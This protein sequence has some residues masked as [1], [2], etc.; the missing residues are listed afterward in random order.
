MEDEEFE[1]LF[2]LEPAAGP[3]PGN[4]PGQ[5]SLSFETV[6]AAL[7]D[8]GE[9]L[10]TA[11]GA[12]QETNRRIEIILGELKQEV[13]AYCG[14]EGSLRG[15]GAAE[16]EEVFRAM[17]ELCK[18]L[19]MGKF[20]VEVERGSAEGEPRGRRLRVE[21]E[22]CPNCSDVPDALRR[23]CAFGEILRGLL[24][25]FDCEGLSLREIKHKNAGERACQF[26]A[27]AR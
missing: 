4:P 2:E 15:E 13:E 25:S 6:W 17:G 8:T 19:G 23:S 18:E 9:H 1:R 22:G 12:I 21:A 16:T 14:V 26:E 5:G 7:L 24:E 10:K 3:P 11:A 20:R 27:S